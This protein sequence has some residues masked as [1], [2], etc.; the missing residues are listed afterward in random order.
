M[1][2]SYLLPLIAVIGLSGC[3]NWNTHIENQ[4]SAINFPIHY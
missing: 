4:T 2:A 3:A 1:R